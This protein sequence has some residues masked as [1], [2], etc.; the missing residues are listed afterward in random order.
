MY[1]GI[2]LSGFL[3]VCALHFVD[4]NEKT[5]DIPSGITPDNWKEAILAPRC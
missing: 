3:G 4:S 5:A 1:C 2:R